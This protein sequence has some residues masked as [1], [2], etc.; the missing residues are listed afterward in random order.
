MNTPLLIANIL[1]LFAFALH[2]FGGD[3]EIKVLEPQNSDPETDQVRQIWTMARSGWHWVSVDLLMATVGLALINFTDYFPHEKMLLEIVA[4]YFFAYA[5]VWLLMITLSKR[6]RLN[7][8]K[9]G[10]W[11]LLLVIGGLVWWGAQGIL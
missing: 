8:L 4:V 7:Y 2:T 10:Q 9:L 11:M 1:C 6:F 5:A 3:R